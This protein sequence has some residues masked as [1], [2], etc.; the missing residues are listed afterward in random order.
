MLTSRR[1]RETGLSGWLNT[2]RKRIGTVAAG[3]GKHKR[4]ACRGIDRGGLPLVGRLCLFLKGGGGEVASR[5]RGPYSQ[6]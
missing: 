1:A 2:C 3:K 6:T 4:G 5:L